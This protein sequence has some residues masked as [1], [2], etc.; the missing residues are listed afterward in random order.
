MDIRALRAA[1]NQAIADGDLSAVA[2]TLADDFVVIIG[3]GT[4]L[5][6]AAYIEAFAHTFEQPVRLHYERTADVVRVSASLSLAAEHG[7]WVGRLFS[8]EGE[9]SVNRKG[10]VDSKGPILFSG[11]YMAMWRNTGSSWQLRSELFVSLT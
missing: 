4:F 6:R 5:S 8:E 9:G 11:T 2:A 10:S 7:H 1:S 3:D